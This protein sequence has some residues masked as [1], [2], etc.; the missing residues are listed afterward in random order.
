MVVAKCDHTAAEANTPM[1][2]SHWS[3]RG[4]RFAPFGGRR[5]SVL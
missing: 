2:A 1:K 5:Q 3:L 4:L